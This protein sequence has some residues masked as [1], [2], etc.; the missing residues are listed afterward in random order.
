MSMTYI[1]TTYP[2]HVK[3]VGGSQA[4][5]SRPNQFSGQFGP[6]IPVRKKTPSIDGAMSVRSAAPGAPGAPTD[7]IMNRKAGVNSSLFQSC[8]ALKKRLADVPDF[9]PYLEEMDQ[10]E[11]E[12]GDATDPVTSMWNMLRRGYPLMTIYN[13]LNPEVPL[14]VNQSKVTEAKLGKAATFKF[15]QACL[16]ELKFPPNECF[17][18][19]DLYGQDTTG[20]VKVSRKRTLHHVLHIYPLGSASGLSANVA[21]ASQ[22]L[23]VIN[24]V[25]D[26]LS[27]SGLL[28]RTEDST[29]SNEV[30]DT[31]PRS[32][33]QKIIDELVTSE[34]DY[35]QHL[36]TLQQFKNQIEQTGAIPGDVV[37]DIFLN[38][39][40]LLDFQRRFLIRIEQQ[41]SL[42]PSAQNW[43]HLFVQY[44]DAFKVYE[45]FIANQS[46]CQEIVS[47]EWDKIKSAP[48][49]PSFQ[50]M[51]ETQSILNSFLL[52]PFVR[53][54]KYPMLLN[55]SCKPTHSIDITSK[56]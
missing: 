49:S 29:S 9:E 32:H 21:D 37:H 1:T 20:F 26:I 10:E 53:L 17:L 4:P 19:T 5:G 6:L 15:L 54:T 16:E 18:I 50:G 35:V 31:G 39:N 48:L 47:R 11:Q 13:A 30:D 23:K 8:L 27:L 3:T 28:L 44:Q 55:V 25:I 34:R 33:Q 38:L 14:E 12:S 42:V 2:T 51:V 45:P 7:N 56:L 36:E 41:N 46:R 22:V 43:G 24:R 40:A 52:K